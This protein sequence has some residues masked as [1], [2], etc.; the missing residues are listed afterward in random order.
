[1]KKA[2][3]ITHVIVAITAT[4]AF[5]F[6]IAK[7]MACINDCFGEDGITEG[8]DIHTEHDQE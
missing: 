1:M 4:T 5:L 6:Q 7:L 8:T 2:P 3:L